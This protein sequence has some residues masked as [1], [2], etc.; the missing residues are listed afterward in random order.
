MWWHVYPLG[1]TG[2]PIRETEAEHPEPHRLTRIEAWLDHVVELGL[3]GIA[4]GPIFAS[5]THGYDTTDHLAIDPRL[6]DEDDLRSLVAAA[7]D[8]GVRVLLDGVFNHVG[9]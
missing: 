1:F 3:N 4:L 5:T 2:A 8:R 6:G 9:R 7:H